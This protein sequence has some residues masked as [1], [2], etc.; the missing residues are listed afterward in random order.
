[1]RKATPISDI[2]KKAK[3]QLL[4][5]YSLAIG[6]FVLLFAI[7]YLLLNIVA[8][9]A[10]SLIFS[11]I[12]G[13]QGANEAQFEAIMTNERNEIMITILYFIVMAVVTPAISLLTT[14]YVY[15][16]RE[17]TMGRRVRS[18]GL[19]YTFKNHPDKVIIISLI[20]YGVRTVLSLPAL[21]FIH[22]CGGDIDNGPDF[23][24]YT[25]LQLAGAIISMIFNIAMS[26]SYLI[27]LDNR[28]LDAIACIKNSMRMMKGHKWRYFCMIMSFAGYWLLMLFSLGVASLWIAPYMEAASIGFYRDL[29]EQQAIDIYA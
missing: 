18:T 27:Y 25:I 24:V 29:R 17:L 3:E 22:Y 8:G 28:E 21:I 12:T 15:I 11:G 6:S 1:M 7:L 19:F 4:G 14:G 2:K 10:E 5:N 23:L 26:Q 13:T 20:S 16:I 9:G